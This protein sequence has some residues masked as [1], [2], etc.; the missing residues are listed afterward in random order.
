MPPSGPATD[1]SINAFL[2]LPTDTTLDGALYAACG[3]FPCPSV[4]RG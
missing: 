2:L 3:T 1:K 4:F